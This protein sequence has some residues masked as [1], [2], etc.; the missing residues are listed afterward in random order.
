MRN[1]LFEWLLRRFYNELRGVWLQYLRPQWILL[2]G[3]LG[4]FCPVGF[5]THCSALNINRLIHARTQTIY[6]NR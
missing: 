2:D 6:I 4:G 5:N 1:N 3:M